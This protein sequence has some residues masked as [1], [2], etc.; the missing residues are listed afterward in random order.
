MEHYSATKKNDIMPLAATWMDL[1][2][3]ILNEVSQRW[4]NIIRYCLYSESKKKKDTNELIYKTENKVMVTKGEG[5]QG[6]ISWQFGTD[7]YTMLHTQ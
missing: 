5:W 1:E 4:T 3:I 7:I 2:I 6:G